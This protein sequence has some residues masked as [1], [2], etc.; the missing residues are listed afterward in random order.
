MQ[1]ISSGMR[2]RRDFSLILDLYRNDDLVGW[3]RRMSV[4]GGALEGLVTDGVEGMLRERHFG[5]LSPVSPAPSALA[6][7]R[8]RLSSSAIGRSASRSRSA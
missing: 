2:M 6:S 8:C 5:L 3:V 4:W 1:Q 7:T